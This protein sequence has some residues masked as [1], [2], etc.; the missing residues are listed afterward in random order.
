MQTNGRRLFTGVVEKFVAWVLSHLACVVY[1]LEGSWRSCLV[2]WPD[3]RSYG[4]GY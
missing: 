2:G 4:D 3:V 1:E